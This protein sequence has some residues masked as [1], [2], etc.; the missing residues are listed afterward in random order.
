MK[1]LYGMKDSAR[2]AIEYRK[3]KTEVNKTIDSI[4]LMNET[5]ERLR[6]YDHFAKEIED[7]NGKVLPIIIKCKLL[8]C[9]HVI[10]L[11]LPADVQGSLEA[12]ISVVSQIGNEEARARVIHSGIGDITQSDIDFATSCGGIKIVSLQVCS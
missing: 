2:R 6:N 9:I 10:Y 3:K 12:F 11:N 1:S 5:S 8:P 7:S 4:D